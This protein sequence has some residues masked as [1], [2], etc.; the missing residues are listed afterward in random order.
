MQQMPR[1]SQGYGTGNQASGRPTIRAL[2]V[3]VTVCIVSSALAGWLTILLVHQTVEWNP[4][5]FFCS[6]L[7]FVA[8]LLFAEGQQYRWAHGLCGLGL[9]FVL[10]QFILTLVVLYFAGYNTGA[11]GLQCYAG[12]VGGDCA[13]GATLYTLIAYAACIISGFT[14]MVVIESLRKEAS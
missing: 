2:R 10:F 13:G 11:N 7:W 5:I 3:A 8:A 6:I 4:S 9:A 14:T 1:S 12:G